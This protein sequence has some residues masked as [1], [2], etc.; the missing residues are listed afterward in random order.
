[1]FYPVHLNLQNRKCVVV[2]GGTVAERK[3]VAMLISG[4]VV[5]VISPESTELLDFLAQNGTIR[6]LRRDYKN[7]DTEGYFLVCAAT[8]TTN[9]NTRVYQEAH[10]ENR[11]ALVN[12][13]DVIPQCTF[14]AASVVTDGQIILSI[15][16]SGKSPA[17]SR[18]IREYFEK[19]LNVSS[20]YTLGYD[21]EHG[22]QKPA[23]IQNMR[24]PYPVYLLLQ[25][26]NCVIINSENTTEMEQRIHLLQRCG[27]NVK[28]LNANSVNLEELEDAF[29]VISEDHYAT[30]NIRK[31][32]GS[33]IFEC[34]DNPAAGTHFTPKLV[35][36][37]NLIISI[38]TKSPK[39]QKTAER[40]HKRLIHQFENRGYGEFIDFLGTLRPKVLSTL[41]TSKE[42]ADYFDNIIDSVRNNGIFVNTFSDRAE[43]NK[44]LTDSCCLRLNHTDCNTECLFNW[45]L[46]G[47][48]TKA[49][50]L[51][52]CLL[53]K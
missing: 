29:L 32:I 19:R 45:I 46:Q 48:L 42:R 36:D 41:S 22:K 13:I 3:V 47:E 38:S 5:T 10:L 17:T 2:G 44:N 24:L 43:N 26:R 18:R 52:D 11:I 1:M 34:L 20:L 53:S 27:A 23:P 9:I 12:V 33:Y 28:C 4:G 51:S 35:I 37:D 40:L 7:G 39:G 8:D 31:N 15:S 21:D 50:E 14:A 30:D 25:D 49:Y 16:T 6:L